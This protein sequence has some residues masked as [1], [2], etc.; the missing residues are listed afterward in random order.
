VQDATVRFGSVDWAANRHAACIVDAAGLVLDQ[1]TVEHT[2]A[3]LTTLVRHFQRE[4]VSRVAI[5]RPDGPVVEALMAAGLEVVVVSSRAVKALRTRY[6][7]AGNKADRSDAYVLADCLRTDGHRWPA[8]QADTPQ[9]LALRAAVRTRKDLVAT[10]VA[11]ANQLRAHLQVV[12]PAAVGVFAEIDSPIMLRFVERFP[13]PDS[14]AW[15]SERR[16]AAWLQANAYCGR[17]PAAELLQRLRR[18]P[19]GQHGPASQAQAVVTLSLVRVL[20]TLVA[21]LAELESHIREQLALHPDGPIFQ[22]LPRSGTVRAA[23]MLVEIGDCRARFPPSQA[24][25]A[26]AGAVP[27]TRA[28][29]QHRV[30][31]FRSA[32]PPPSSAA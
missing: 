20:R 30:V 18:A 5:E 26:L 13:T 10:R 14:A 15:L 19:V 21:E 4:R 8:L 2:A 1:F 7:L 17:R 25:A 12:F 6:G 27:S 3:G 24:L 9:T 31:T 28:S 22:S 32:L 16:L 29:G 23:A 11:T